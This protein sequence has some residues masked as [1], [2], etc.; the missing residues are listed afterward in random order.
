ME[1]GSCIGKV[2]DLIFDN[3]GD[4]QG[5]LYNPK[6]VLKGKRLIP[7]E[8]I[9][10]IGTDGLLVNE[11]DT[12]QFLKNSKEYFSLEH[13]NR[14]IGKPLLT[15]EGEKLG[16]VHDVYFQEE[17]GKIEGIEV[18]DGWFADV[19]EGRKVVKTTNPPEIGD[20]ILIVHLP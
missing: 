3:N 16:L 9:R 6:N 11:E 19:T 12:A 18:T 13:Q 8:T 7:L 1:N 15:E 14:V 2:E 5:I 17:L 4:I 20:D 10:S